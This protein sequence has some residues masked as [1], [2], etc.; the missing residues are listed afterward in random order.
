MSRY[1]DLCFGFLR[2]TT[3]FFVL[4]SLTSFCF[5]RP[6][7][8]GVAGSKIWVSEKFLNP[9]ALVSSCP[10]RCIGFLRGQPSA[11]QI[12]MVQEQYQ[13]RKILE[14]FVTSHKKYPNEFPLRKASVDQP[15]LRVVATGSSSWL[16]VKFLSD[17]QWPDI[18][19]DFT[20]W[21]I[22]V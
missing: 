15:Y 21:C 16:I 5:I 22:R 7:R 11:C 14:H 17:L 2:Y 9:L 6:R 3:L 10:L 13:K 12:Q 19:A 20:L 18:S 4:F 8:H 1:R